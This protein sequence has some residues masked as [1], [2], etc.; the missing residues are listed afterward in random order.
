MPGT[1][2][3]HERYN[4]RYYLDNKVEINARNK[5]RRDH[6]RGI[7]TEIKKISMCRECGFSDYRALQFH[8]RNPSEKLFTVG[9]NGPKTSLKKLHEEIEKCDVLCANCHSI[10]HSDKDA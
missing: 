4:K 9:V 3:Y 8:H 1:K 7:I 5:A 6:L 10:L 2:E